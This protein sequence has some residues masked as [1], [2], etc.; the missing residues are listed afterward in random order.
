MAVYGEG[1]QDNRLPSLLASTTFQC[2]NYVSL[3]WYLSAEFPS[4]SAQFIEVDWGRRSTF[5]DHSQL[6]YSD[7]TTCL[8]I[9]PSVALIVNDVEIPALCNGAVYLSIA[10]FNLQSS[11]SWFSEKII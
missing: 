2:G 3:T 5:E 1:A 7:G 11:I 8:L 9:D 4:V 10:S 6:F